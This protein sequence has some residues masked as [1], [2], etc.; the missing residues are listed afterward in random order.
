[1]K[2][3]KHKCFECESKYKLEYDERIVEDDPTYCPFC[4]TY[5]QESEMEQDE[6]Y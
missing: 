1:M 5:I 3:L 4:G 6:D 2:V